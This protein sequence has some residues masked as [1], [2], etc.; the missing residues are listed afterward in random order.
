MSESGRTYGRPFKGHP[1]EAS[2][3]RAWTRLRADH[4]DAPAVAH[5]LFVAVLAT[6]SD[7]IDVQLSTAGDRLKITATGAH[8]LSLRHSHGPGWRIISGLSRSTGVTTDEHGL[9]AQMEES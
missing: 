8:P 1:I 2:E 4:P 7:V 3:V 5:E 9:W 6:G